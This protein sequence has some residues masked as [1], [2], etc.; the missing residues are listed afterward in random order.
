MDRL[1]RSGENYGIIS[2]DLN[3]LKKINDTQ[4]HNSGDELISGFAAIVSETF[5]EGTVVGRMGGDEFIVIIEA[6]GRVKVEKLIED[7]QYNIEAANKEQEKFKY[8]VSYGFAN[9]REIASSDGFVNSRKVYELAD[10]RMYEYKR[11]QKAVGN[12]Q[13]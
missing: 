11:K 4:G 3:D 5:G 7:L 13:G 1:S 6:L 12:K 10:E 9:S 8:S 2:L